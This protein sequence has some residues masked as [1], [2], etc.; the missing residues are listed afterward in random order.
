MTSNLLSGDLEYK[1]FIEGS[2]EGV[3][4]D[5]IPVNYLSKIELELKYDISDNSKV[6]SVIIF[7]ENNLSSDI[8]FGL[9][10]GSK[11][12]EIIS[13]Q[14]GSFA[15]GDSL[16]DSVIEKLMDLYQSGDFSG[17]GS[18]QALSGDN[19]TIDRALFSL[20][21]KYIDLNIGRQQ[22][23]WGAGYAFNPTD[24][25]NNKNP[26]DPKAPKSG[27]DIIKGEISIGDNSS[28]EMV[29]SPDSDFKNSSYGARF[30]SNIFN[31]DYSLSATKYETSFRK[32][33]SLPEKVIFG[34][35]FTGELWEEGL[36]IWSESIFVNQVYGESYDSF[37]STYV[38][39]D[40]GV[41]LTLESGIYLMAEYFHNGLG[42]S[43]SKDYS[44]L[45]LIRISGGDM[46]GFGRDYLFVGANDT[47]FD[48]YMV[49]VYSLINL[50]DNSAVVMPDLEY[51]YN[52]DLSI[53]F[54]YSINLGSSRRSEFGSYKDSFGVT[55][56]VYF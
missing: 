29:F 37:D 13:S 38:Q 56:K 16:T 51:S 19:I 20:Y 41:D 15:T 50:S 42:S 14:F 23:A 49:G 48:D 6:E 54:N 4:T 31:F 55:A 12:N 3:A 10:N 8:S 26:Q 22:V 34:F 7:R 44:S 25:W 45:D 47:Y 18:T 36:G 27:V 11:I 1:G 5:S 30:R 24:I 39:I 53:K 35:D 43:G 17:L 32:I 46:P 28:V 9:K 33:L 2:L 40:V 21:L 52:D